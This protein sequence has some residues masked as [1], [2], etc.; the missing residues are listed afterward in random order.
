[1]GQDGFVV[2]KDFGEFFERYPLRVRHWL[3]RRLRRRFAQDTILDLEQDLLLYLCTLAPESRFR[4]R[5]T[6]GRPDGCT[7]VIQC[8][9]PVRHF[10]AAAGRFHN[11]INLCLANRLNTIL[12]RHRLN[13][14]CN[15]RN[16][17]L[18]HFHENDDRPE[19][20]SEVDEAYLLRHS[21]TFAE[22]CRRRARTEDPILKAYAREFEQF[23]QQLKPGLVAVMYEIQRSATLRDAEKNLGMGN[24]EFR[25]CRQELSLLNIRFL[26]ERKS[27]LRTREF[28][29]PLEIQCKQPLKCF[30]VRN[31]MSESG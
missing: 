26:G 14:L 30:C 9:D 23:V 18:A 16:V 1:V 12:A 31:C 2:P 20:A 27:L 5:G 24:G 6:N 19:S 11:F 17:S 7:D 13:P 10:G 22:E 4:R 21:G 3:S 29:S 28:S 25:K 15:P 8:F